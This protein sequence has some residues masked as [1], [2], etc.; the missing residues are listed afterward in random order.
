MVSTEYRKMKGRGTMKVNNVAMSMAVAASLLVQLDARA[1]F[2]TAPAVLPLGEVLD[3][4]L[5]DESRIQVDMGGQLVYDGSEHKAPVNFI[6]IDGKVAYVA[7]TLP[8]CAKYFKLTLKQ[9]RG[10][11]QPSFSEFSM[12]DK[13]NARINTGLTQLQD[14]TPASSLTPGSYSRCGNYPNESFESVACI[15]DGNTSTKWFSKGPDWFQSDASDTNKWISLVMRLADDAPA[16]DHYTL[17]TENDGSYASTRAPVVW[18]LEGSIDGNDWFV[19]HDQLDA[20]TTMPTSV[21]TESS[22][23]AVGGG[24]WDLALT[25]DTATA[26]GEHQLVVSGTGGFTGTRSVPF[27]ILPKV[28]T[29]AMVQVEDADYTYDGTAKEPAVVVADGTPSIITADDYSVAYSNNVDVGEA[30]VTVTGRNNYTGAV[31]NHFTIGKAGN[32]WT[33]EPSIDDWMQGETPSVPDMGE[34]LFGSVVVTYGESGTTPPSVFGNYTATFT[35]AETAN[36]AGLSKEVPFRVKSPE[37]EALKV[38]F[39]DHP[40]IIGANGGGGWKVTLTNDIDSADLPIE[41]LDNLGPVTLDLNGHDLVAGEGLPAISIVVGGENGEPTELTIINSGES[42]VT[43]QGGAGAPAVEVVDGTR[44][45]VVVNVG[46]RVI[47]RSGGDGVP[48]VV[49]EVGTN[50]GVILPYELTDAM[51]GEIAVQPFTGE[52]VTPELAVYDEAH[53]WTLVEG[54]DFVVTWK[55]NV[56]PGVATVV[57][58]GKGNYIGKVSCTFVIGTPVETTLDAGKYFKATLAELGYDVPTNGTPYSVKAYGLPAGLKLMSNKAE[59]KKVKRGKKVTT[60]VVRPV[61][62]EW[63]IEGVPTAALDFFTNPPYLVITA[64]GNTET[65][66][67]PV[68]VEAQDVTELP[69]LALGEPINEQ[70]YLPGVTNGWTVSGLPTGLKYTAKLVT[71]TKKKGKKVVSVTTNALPY[72]VYGKTTKAGL[73]TITAKKKIGSFYETMKYRVLV[74]PAAVNADLFTDSLT[75]ITTMA[76]VPIAWDLTGGEAVSS[77]PAVPFVPSSVSGKVAKVTGLPNGLTFAAANT[78]A[79]TN[80]KKKTGKY[81]KQAGQTIVGTPTKAGT[82]VVTLTKNFTTGTGKKKMTVAKTAQILW[83]VVAND[84]ELSLGFNENGGV[85]ESG[86][87]GLNY[88]DL[89]AFSATEGA[90]V[91]ASGLPKG[92]ALADLGGGNYAFK[93]FTTKAGTYLV[94]VKATLNGKTVTQRVALKVDGLPAWAKGTFNGV[95]STNGDSYSGIATITVSS[96]GKISGKFLEHGTN[97][98][99]SAASYASLSEIYNFDT[100]F[101]CSNVVAKYA[102]KVTTT[103]KGKKKTVTKYLTR[104]FKLAVGETDNLSPARGVAMLSEENGSYV[105]AYQ[106]LWGQTAY[107]NLGKKLFTTKSGKKTLAYKTWSSVEAA[108]LGTYDTL[109]MKVSTAGAV[110]ATYKFFKGTFD[111]KTKKPQYATYTC[112]TTLIPTTPA[113]SDMFAGAVLLSFQPDAKTG[114]PGYGGMVG[115]PFVNRMVPVPTKAALALGNWFTGEFNG[116]GDV[117]FPVGGD[118]EILNGLF[119]VNVASSLAFTGTFTGT[120]GS[121]ASFSGTF[122]KDGSSYVANGVL[123]K[124]K[125][126]TMS[127]SLSCDPGPYAG[128]NEGFGELSGWSSAAPDEPFILLNC[129]WQ[130]IWKR[131][132]LAAEWK[133]AFAAGTEKTILLHKAFQS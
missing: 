61:N 45:G 131:S 113:D 93:G 31:T 59:T 110:T 97:W 27:T 54:S 34:P 53:D 74:T 71:T 47:V 8:A 112:A 43:V 12:Y 29:D 121:T 130:N 123:I 2:D 35:V 84:A 91:T 132:D 88:G 52:E 122:S 108:G 114:F 6:K 125:D 72:S 116:Y 103:V 96:A 5:V 83:K 92:I 38:I 41:F 104:T 23:Y 42:D 44:D 22:S 79:Y 117:Q 69:D 89:L 115:Y 56:R 36:Y 124:V 63:W 64:N 57:I 68:E 55:D 10:G 26:A 46:E 106:N 58:T 129:A 70:F 107:K 15:F 33:R 40:A 66:P 75:N 65:L 24:S 82:Y 30:T 32:E 13:L 127:M 85:V 18:T 67:L 76:Y 51:V 17:T 50:N 111:K 48:G 99:F 109:S 94:T 81:L 87:V 100:A 126:E 101:I 77:V 120:D 20:S 60:I 133:P 4:S 98:T 28:L 14:M 128:S 9:T 21:T 118:T 73:F 95:V 7:E 102:Y 90:M 16:L 80:P 37:E 19:V 11:L 1:G 119:T 62:V 3:I 25:G 78:Y 105:V 49:G 86:S 39:G